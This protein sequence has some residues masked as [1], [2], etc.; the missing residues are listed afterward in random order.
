MHPCDP[1][2]YSYLPKA[3]SSQNS[4]G[5]SA[6]ANLP[7][8]QARHVYAPVEDQNL[9][10]AQFVQKVLPSPLYLPMAQSM[11]PCDPSRF[12]YLPAAQR[13]QWPEP[14]PGAF[15][16]GLHKVQAPACDPENRPA[17]Q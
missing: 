14:V 13:V 2:R 16:P 12:S 6:V 17:A 4:V 7:G 3:H 8:K 9:P 1:I 15:L 11:H 10:E 5:E